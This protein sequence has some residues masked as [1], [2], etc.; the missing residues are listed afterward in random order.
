V[1]TRERRRM[2]LDIIWQHASR[3]VIEQPLAILMTP[4][5]GDSLRQLLETALKVV[6]GLV[7][8]AL[9]W[10]VSSL[11]HRI[12]ERMARGAD[13]RRTETLLLFDRTARVTLLILGAVCALGTTGID[14]SALVAGLGLTGF[15]L[16]FALRD[17]LSNFLAGTLIKIYRPFRRGDRIRVKDFEG[18]VIEIDLRYTTLQADGKKFL[19]PNHT[20]FTEPVTLHQPKPAT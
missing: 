1:W 9:F 17:A 18:V 7:V 8:F 4:T 10:A 14:V 13:Q 20:L 16:G 11:V 15:A 5:A 2:A 12:L 6:V 19:I 3:V